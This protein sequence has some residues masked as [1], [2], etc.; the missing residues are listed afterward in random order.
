MATI[1]TSTNTS[2]TF[3][4]APAYPD[5]ISQELTLPD[6]TATVTVSLSSKLK[7]SIKTIQGGLLSQSTPFF[8]FHVG[9][10]LSNSNIISDS[11]NL[12]LASS[13]PTK[14]IIS[15]PTNLFLA[16][17]EPTKQ[18]ISK[19]INS[20]LVSSN[21]TNNVISESTN[22]LLGSSTASSTPTEVI[23]EESNDIST[24]RKVMIP[25]VVSLSVLA[26]LLVLFLIWY[27]RRKRSAKHEETEDELY[28]TDN[29]RRDEQIMKYLNRADTS[30][31]LVKNIK[32]SDAG[33][34]AVHR[35]MPTFAKYINAPVKPDFSNQIER[36]DAEFPLASNFKRDDSSTMSS[37]H[38]RSTK[39]L[40]SEENKRE[41]IN[42][43]EDF[44]T[45]SQTLNLGAKH[46]RNPERK[47]SVKEEFQKFAENLNLAAMHSRNLERNSR[48]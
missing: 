23:V 10:I 13:K 44:Q 37:Y 19:P 41:S 11:T 6:E 40:A 18:I 27:R 33:N 1:I 48:E 39:E 34:Q 21:P 36:H 17:S 9:G 15:K 24:T 32:Y 46:S 35:N 29:S 28:Q 47:E 38:S 3:N 5:T 8:V 12:L 42:F 7:A 45:F 2:F 22:S 25:L 20:L 30:S 16:S 43:D 26:L 31:P 14:Q 4:I